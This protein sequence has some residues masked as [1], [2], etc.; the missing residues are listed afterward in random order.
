MKSASA[1]ALLIAAGA[2]L[3]AVGNWP[4]GVYTLVRWIV[5]GSCVFAAFS[6]YQQGRRW[7]MFAAIAIA[8]VFNPIAPL[9]F[10]KATWRV[11]DV[12]AAVGCAALAIASE[13]H[14]RKSGA[15]NP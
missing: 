3:F 10:N 7:P 5:C 11:L 15:S 2:A 8:V 9:Y 4:Y 1:I 14:E 6:L 13:R 12:V